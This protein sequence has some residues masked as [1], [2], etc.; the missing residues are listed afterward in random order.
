MPITFTFTLTQQ[1]TFELRC[2]YGSR[3]LDKS[4]LL[5]LIDQCEQNYYSKESDRLSYLTE[6]GRQLYFWLDGKEGWLRNALD[7]TDEKTIYL[8]LSQISEAQGLKRETERVALG[9]AHLPWELL[10]DRTGFLLERQDITVLPV[11]SVQQ[12]NTK[13]V[14]Q[15]V[16]E[17]RIIKIADGNTRL[18][19]WLLDVVNKPGLAADELLTKLE[20]TQQ[21][22]REN[23]LAEV[24]LGRFEDALAH[25]QQALD[26]CPE[27]DDIRK[28]AILH[29]MA[30]LIAQS[31]DIDGAIALY[32]QSL[33]I[34]ERINDVQGKAAILHQMAGLIAQ[35]GDIDGAIALYHQSLEIKERIND[36]KGKAAT[37][38]N[39]AGLIAQNG[40]IDGAI[41]LYH[42][43]L[44]INERINNVQG[45]AATLSNMAYLISQSGDI[46]GAIALYQQ[47]LE[48][49]ERIND[50]KGKAATLHQMA[51]FIAQSGDID[52][53]IA[54]YH[55]SLEIKERINDVQGKAATLHAIAYLTAQNGDI[56][57]AIA[58]YHQS[59]EIN[60]RIN[61][62]QGKAA[63][64]HAMAGLTAQSG[65]IDGVIALYHQSLE[66]KE[67][68]NNVQGKA[69]TLASMAYLAGETGDKVRQLDLNLQ[70]ASAFA[71][72]RAYI[73]LVTVLVNLGV[74]DKSNGLVYLAQATWLIIKIQTPFTKTIQL[75]R[76]L[77]DAVPQGDEMEALLGAMAVFFCYQRGK[78]HPQLEEFQKGSLNMI[79]AAASAQGIE[80]QEA[81]DTW[82][83]QQRLNDPKYYIPRLL[84]RL[85]EIVGDEWLFERF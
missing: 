80:T 57:G 1:Q 79:S 38:S 63:T 58:L 7:E 84:Q 29:Q 20:G 82:F 74:A 22:F 75:I 16:Q 50:V 44:Q 3:R 24:V 25:C 47:S 85:E 15:Q 71:Q 67:R 77:Y 17:Q 33:Q 83:V 48:I 46:D 6:I 12:R 14:Q 81:F 62:V 37:L 32:H 66:I 56:D 40:D 41:E 70:A 34:N 59:L 21:E 55:Q 2:D 13:E 61:N 54:L 26:L 30:G 52:G 69:A 51:A 23:I 19:K 9:L 68:I 78:N 42:Q 18:L 4:E 11:R 65:D 36:V 45:K 43:S 53:A 28:A 35:S 31:G 27:E 5:A 10:C 39:M 8:D 49:E 64:L 60:E 76:D 73:D 72:I